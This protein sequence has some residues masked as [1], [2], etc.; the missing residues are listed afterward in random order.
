MT[1]VIQKTEMVRHSSLPTW[2]LS[3]LT[4]LQ[5]K[6]TW[7]KEVSCFSTLK[8]KVLQKSQKWESSARLLRAGCAGLV[9][10]AGGPAADPGAPEGDHVGP[11]LHSTVRPAVD[12]HPEELV[13]RPDALAGGAPVV[14]AV[15]GCQPLR[16]P[17]EQHF[18]RL[19]QMR[20]F[21]SQSWVCK[22]RATFFFPNRQTN[23]HLQPGEEV[24]R[25]GISAAPYGQ[26]PVNTR[27]TRKVS[28]EVLLSTEF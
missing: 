22:N 10:P 20:G 2:A 14:Q 19:Q 23:T 18:L 12:V 24:L 26:R 17:P 5:I 15:L 16:G 1:D 25:S 6:V 13:A 4:V 27:S 3:T 11:G 21:S 28:C 9:Q 8:W 7:V